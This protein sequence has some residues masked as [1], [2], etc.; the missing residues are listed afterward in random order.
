MSGWRIDRSK[1]FEFDENFDW[2]WLSVPIVGTMGTM[3]IHRSLDFYVS[4]QRWS[5]ASK[6]IGEQLP[7]DDMALILAALIVHN[8]QS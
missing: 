3:P 1:R 4:E 6:P 5:K 8:N 2:E 7:P